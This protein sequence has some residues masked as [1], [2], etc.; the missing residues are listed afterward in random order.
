MPELRVGGNDCDFWK[1]THMM[2]SAGQAAS[3]LVGHTVH[4]IDT[5]GGK[6]FIRSL[7][8]PPLPPFSPSPSPSP[9]HLLVP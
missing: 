1:K 7:F 8:S 4:R 3:A 2:E 9:I 6:S 5:G